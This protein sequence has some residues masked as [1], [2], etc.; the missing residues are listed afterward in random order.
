MIIRGFVVFNDN[1]A[2]TP[3]VEGRGHFSSPDKTVI[4]DCL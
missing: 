1:Q 2:V 4:A 3:R